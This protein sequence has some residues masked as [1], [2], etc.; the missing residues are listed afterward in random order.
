MILREQLGSLFH[1][2]DGE[3]LKKFV[4]LGLDF[5]FLAT[6]YVFRISQKPPGI[7]ILGGFLLKKGLSI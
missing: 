4:L 5:G 6:I 1:A 3:E 2:F 7:C